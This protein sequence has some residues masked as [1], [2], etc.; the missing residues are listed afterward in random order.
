M[1]LRRGA[2]YQNSAVPPCVSRLIIVL[3]HCCA[4]RSAVGRTVF[5]GQLS[6]S[7][8]SLSF[9]L[10]LQTCVLR[11]CGIVSFFICNY[12]SAPHHLSTESNQI[13]LH[14]YYNDD[15]RQDNACIKPKSAGKFDSLAAVHLG[16]KILIPPALI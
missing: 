1:F 14:K 15:E 16:D 2:K 6:F 8:E 5:A 13:S 3:T 10:L 7:R 12:T 11:R 4:N 9:D